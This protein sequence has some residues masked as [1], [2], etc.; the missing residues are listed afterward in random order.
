MGAEFYSR[1]LKTP[2]RARAPEKWLK[3]FSLLSQRR[4]PPDL[5]R[6]Q[7]F[8]LSPARPREP[9]QGLLALPRAGTWKPGTT[10]PPEHLGSPTPRFLPWE[11]T[12]RKPLEDSVSSLLLP[13]QE[14]AGF[15][16]QPPSAG[17]LYDSVVRHCRLGA[18]GA[19]RWGWGTGCKAMTPLRSSLSHSSF[20]LQGS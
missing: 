20:C 17:C 7:A 5:H 1:C 8:E 6:T 9:L 3:A 11:R 15:Y 14:G 18:L 13:G 19:Q 16:G 12:L 10:T 4:G 2:V